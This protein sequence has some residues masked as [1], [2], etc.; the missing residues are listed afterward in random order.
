MRKKVILV[1]VLICFVASYGFSFFAVHDMTNLLQ[2]IKTFIQEKEQFIKQKLQWVDE[3]RHMSEQAKQLERFWEDQVRDF[4]NIDWSNLGTLDGNVKSILDSGIKAGQTFDSMGDNLVNGGEDL[5][6][7]IKEVGDKNTPDETQKDIAEIGAKAMKKLNDKFINGGG[8]ENGA[9]SKE[10]YKKLIIEAK[11]EEVNEYKKRI[12]D[13]EKERDEMNKNINS[14]YTSLFEFSGKLSLYDVLADR[15]C[16]SVEEDK[17]IDRSVENNRIDK[18]VLK[19][20]KFYKPN[21]L[22]SGLSDQQA[23]ISADFQDPDSAKFTFSNLFNDDITGGKKVYNY[24]AMKAVINQF[25]LN[26]IPKT[27]K[28]YNPKTWGNTLKSY[29]IEM[30]EED[31][32]LMNNVADNLDDLIQSAGESYKKA[33]SDYKTSYTLFENMKKCEKNIDDSIKDYKDAIKRTC[34]FVK[35]TYNEDISENTF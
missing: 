9:Y 12:K 25:K 34:S 31:E 17:N 8:E 35:D 4:T 11:K 29:G 21:V 19:N 28:W 15:R 6:K 22:S 27:S 5:F 3:L 13:K 30:S 18:S 16:C 33:S 24:T 1:L 23:W 7:K 26:K 10:E 20:V 2:N 32:K 14:Y